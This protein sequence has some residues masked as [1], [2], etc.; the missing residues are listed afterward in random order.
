M[1][2]YISVIPL[3]LP[4]D[5]KLSSLIVVPADLDLCSTILYMYIMN[6]FKSIHV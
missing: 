2:I 4:L 5:A 1:C 6:N 3:L